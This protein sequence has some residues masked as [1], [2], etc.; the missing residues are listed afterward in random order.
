MN[1]VT[2]QLTHKIDRAVDECFTDVKA[3]IFLDNSNDDEKTKIG[4]ITATLIERSKMPVEDDEFDHI[5]ACKSDELELIVSWL[6]HDGPRTTLPSLA[7]K[8]DM[9]NMRAVLH[10]DS[11]HLLQDSH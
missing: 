7:S 6:F 9:H 3:D 8:D 11:F 5:M 4:A 1:N 2:I 10:I